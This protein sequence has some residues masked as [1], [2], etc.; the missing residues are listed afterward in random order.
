MFIWATVEVNLA[1]IAG[2]F[3]FL[4]IIL[5][6][7]IEY[8]RSESAGFVPARNDTISLRS[9]GYELENEAS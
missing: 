1:I 6:R 8:S 3:P 4:R 7:L 9:E 5:D 2:S